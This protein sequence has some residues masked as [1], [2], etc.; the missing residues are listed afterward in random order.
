VRIKIGKKRTSRRRALG[1]P[2]RCRGSMRGAARRR[3][4]LAY[5]RDLGEGCSLRGYLTVAS[6]HTEVVWMRESLGG[7]MRGMRMGR[8]SA[9]RTRVTVNGTNKLVCFSGRPREN[10]ERRICLNLTP[11]WSTMITASK[12]QTSVSDNN[13]VETSFKNGGVEPMEPEPGRSRSRAPHLKS[14]H[15]EQTGPHKVS[16]KSETVLW[17][18][19]DCCTCEMTMRR[20]AM[21]LQMIRP[22]G[23]KPQV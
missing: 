9:G 22:S 14:A 23:A 1:P 13:L 12:S 21:S 10:E 2:P 20:R 17:I 4:R 15:H 6:A 19:L 16:I 11:G 3:A 18:Y 8:V 5:Q 7:G